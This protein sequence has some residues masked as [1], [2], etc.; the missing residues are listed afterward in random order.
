M[1]VQPFFVHEKY[2][3]DQFVFGKKPALHSFY[4]N[5]IT[6]RTIVVKLCSHVYYTIALG[7]N[8]QE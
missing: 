5:I 1:Q 8:N 7:C 2:T 3:F 4:K 6:K